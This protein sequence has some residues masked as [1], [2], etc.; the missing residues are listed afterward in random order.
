MMKVKIVND[1][2]NIIEVESSDFDFSTDAQNIIFEQSKKYNAARKEKTLQDPLPTHDK[3]LQMSD[4]MHLHFSRMGIPSIIENVCKNGLKAGI[5]AN[6]QFGNGEYMTS[7]TGKGE[8]YSVVDTWGIKCDCEY[9]EAAKALPLQ[10]DTAEDL[11]YHPAMTYDE[12]NDK[13]VFELMQ[14][15]RG[16]TD[17]DFF[18]LSPEKRNL[19]LHFATERTGFIIDGRSEEFKQDCLEVLHGSTRH[20]FTGDSEV[21]Q[22]EDYCKEVNDQQ[23]VFNH[24][25]FVYGVPS[26]YITGVILPY[27]MLNFNE[28]LKEVFQYLNDKTIVAPNGEVLYTP[29]EQLSVE[30]NYENFFN[31]KEQH[32]RV[33]ESSSKLYSDYQKEHKGIEQV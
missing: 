16:M 17:E 10:G 11:P 5:F 12:M 24:S 9:K 4:G 28:F 20:I 30:Q 21:I 13:Y 31:K 7:V 18:Q 2:G 1:E 23:I 26:K 22:E 27:F 14:Q 6:I 8:T 25:G 15:V 3:E 29:N 33:C 32:L 19:I